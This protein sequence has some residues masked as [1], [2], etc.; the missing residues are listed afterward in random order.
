MAAIKKKAT[1]KPQVAALDPTPRHLWLASLGM[2]VAARRESKAAVLRV[3]SRIENTVADAR[4]ALRRAEADLRAGVDGVRGQ[5]APK[6]ACFSNEVEARLAP[7]VAKLGLAPK[8][9]R[10]PRKARKSAAKKPVARRAVRKP[11]R[12]VAKKAAT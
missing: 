3:T 1:R 11:A 2:L 9:R 4:Y 7:I 12:R 8:A 5:V 10:A 6:V